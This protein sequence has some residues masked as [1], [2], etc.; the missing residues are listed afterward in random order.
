MIPARAAGAPVGE[1]ISPRPLDD[2]SLRWLDDHDTK[3]TAPL[4]GTGQKKVVSMETFSSIPE[5]QRWRAATKTRVGHVA[6]LGYL[7]QGHRS[8]IRRARAENDHVVVTL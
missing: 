5:Y 2:E 4:V 6:S 8:L 3:A 1:G 7:H